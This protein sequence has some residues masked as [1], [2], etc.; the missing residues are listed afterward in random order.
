MAYIIKTTGEVFETQPKNGTDF[1]LEELQKI[2]G[3]YIE[4]VSLH[5][6]RLIVCDE[7]GKCKG[8][9]RNH[10]ATEMFRLTLLTTD[11][12]VGDVLVCR[13]NEIK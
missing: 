3:G 9:D 10:K 11:F 6:G 2:V 4:V 13:E 7:Q 8:K 1:S 12:L 5:D